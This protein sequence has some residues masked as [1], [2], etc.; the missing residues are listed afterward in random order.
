MRCKDYTYGS[1]VNFPYTELTSQWTPA[2]KS[3]FTDGENEVISYS[4]YRDESRFSPYREA[5]FIFSATEGWRAGMLW[6]TTDRPTSHSESAA[7]RRFNKG[8]RSDS[9]VRIL[10]SR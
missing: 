5:Y 1:G 4:F 9:T 8:E 3:I 6:H 2:R 7:A 10:M